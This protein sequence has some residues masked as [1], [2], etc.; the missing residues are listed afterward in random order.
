MLTRGQG[1]GGISPIAGFS[2]SL[3]NRNQQGQQ[4]QQQQQQNN[5]AIV[6]QQPQSTNQQM[7]VEV[8][9]RGDVSSSTTINNFNNNN[10]D[11]DDDND[12][13]RSSLLDDSS[14]SGGSTDIF[15]T[16]GSISRPI[17]LTNSLGSRLDLSN[18]RGSVSGGGSNRNRLSNSLSGSGG[19]SRFS[20]LVSQ[21][22]RTRG[23]VR[24]ARQQAAKSTRRRRGTE[25]D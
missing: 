21:N 8:G 16:L 24:P 13:T 18:L 17:S 5:D 2:G 14:D 10:D 25:R 22:T 6:A 1:L 19:G 20:S 4:Q 15:G 12:D 3:F 11:D 7:F 23:Q 9:E